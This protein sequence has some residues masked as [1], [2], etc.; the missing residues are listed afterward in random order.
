MAQLNTFSFEDTV[1][2]I[3]RT[4]DAWK[5]NPLDNTM[6]ESG[7]VKV[8]TIPANTGGT[9]RHKEIP[10]G[11][12]YADD[13]AEWGLTTK[14]RVQQG[15]Y[16]DTTAR[17]FSKGIDITYEMRTLNKV[18]EIYNA[19]NFI[20]W[21]CTR[22]EDLNLS[23]F[24][25]FGVST[26]YTNKNGRVVDVSTGDGLSLWNTAHTLTGSSTTYRNQLASNP[27][28]S[29]SSLELMEDLYVTNI[30][31]NLGEQVGSN[32][33]VIFST[34]NP[35]LVNTIKRVIQSTAQ[36]SAPNEWVVNVYQGKYSH[37]ILNKLDMNANWVKDA[38]KK[39]SWWMA[40]TMISSFYHDIYSAP[41]MKSPTS[42]NNGE[43][44]ETLDWTWTAIDMNDSCVVAWRWM[45]YSLWDGS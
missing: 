41:E 8:N 29:E 27:A 25:S 7:I 16:K 19:A 17:T 2:L 34:D 43:D 22:R 18:Q 30:Y 21:V 1:D 20:G 42:G 26:S 32:P 28:F 9:R 3:N 13:K 5:T 35:T 31:T 33:D 6:K 37:K 23:L 38:A 36:I 40:D 10:V 44:I 14:T 15:Y 24:L 45:T 11:E 39:S 12:L 4:F